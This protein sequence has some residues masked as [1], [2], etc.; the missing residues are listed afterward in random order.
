[1]EQDNPTQSLE[2]SYITYLNNQILASNERKKKEKS[3]VIDDPRLNQFYA[4]DKLEPDS[5]PAFLGRN[6]L[7][8]ERRRQLYYISK[9]LGTNHERASTVGLVE[10]DKA[11]GVSSGRRMGNDDGRKSMEYVK[12]AKRLNPEDDS[13]YLQESHHH[14]RK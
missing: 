9:N 6:P 2:K 1:M 10:D 7:S 13:G 3:S 8:H 4:S 12:L 11:V 14:A 5:S